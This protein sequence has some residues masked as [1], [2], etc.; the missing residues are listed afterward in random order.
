MMESSDLMYFSP[1]SIRFAILA[2]IIAASVMDAQ[3]PA[4]S[5]PV[6]GKK[7]SPRPPLFSVSGVT[8]RDSDKTAAKPPQKTEKPAESAAA[9]DSVK[10]NDTASTKPDTAI[11]PSK[12]ET[13]FDS[14]KVIGSA[15]GKTDSL[16]SVKPAGGAGEASH[17]MVQPPKTA[18]SVPV[19]PK[20]V[21]PKAAAPRRNGLDDLFD[22]RFV[23]LLASIIIIG[24][25]LRRVL[26][27]ADRPAFVT[28]TR[29]SIMDKE[30]QTAC[31]YI[32]KNYRN[33][34]L[35]LE[36]VCKALV[37]GQAFLDALFHQELG[38]NVEEFIRHVRVNRARMLIEKDTATPAEVAAQETGFPDVQSFTGAFSSI[39]GIPYER[40]R[41]T[42][43]NNAS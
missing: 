6:A 2:L 41:D 21:S 13:K 10:K 18:A 24:L 30:V 9:S 33:P 8:P 40:Y 4:R 31:R 19:I 5:S 36:T 14:P 27:K 34:Q 42:R 7:P 11:F 29:L 37:T 20:T 38:L 35:S 25:Y 23:F 32:E 26:K 3:Q 16:P 43:K 22:L 17:E 12:A 39:V 28:T 1:M 15:F